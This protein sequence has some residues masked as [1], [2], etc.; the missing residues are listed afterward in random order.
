MPESKSA[1]VTIG[2]SVM[3]DA[4]GFGRFQVEAHNGSS[5]FLIDEPIAVGGLGSGPNPYDLLVSALGACTLMT[6]RLYANHKNWPLDR[7]R[8]RVTRCPKGLNARDVFDTEILLEGDLDDAQRG[9]L[10]EIAGHCPVHRTLD[11]GVDFTVKEVAHGAFLGGRTIGDC[12]HVQNM[13][14]VRAI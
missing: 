7:I 1:P 5:S 9:R 13:E 14:D 10:I 12:D 2:E 6:V 8:V 4:T 3:L 11:R